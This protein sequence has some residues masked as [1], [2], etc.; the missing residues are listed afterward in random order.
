MAA[1]AGVQAHTMDTSG[2]DTTVVH[3]ML[4]RARGASRRDFSGGATELAENRQLA[5]SCQSWHHVLLARQIVGT[6]MPLGHWSL[7]EEDSSSAGTPSTFWASPCSE[8]PA[9][10][11]AQSWR[12]MITISEVYTMMCVLHAMAM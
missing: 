12:H 3:G 10:R 8:S 7:D 11:P 2:F 5:A 4:S 1:P 9:A 6:R